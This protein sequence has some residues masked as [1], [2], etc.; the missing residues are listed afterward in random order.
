M[1]TATRKKK[2]APHDPDPRDPLSQSDLQMLASA[3]N[4]IEPPRADK[5]ARKDA[6]PGAIPFDAPRTLVGKADP[7]KAAGIAVRAAD[8]GRVLMLQ[9]STA[10]GRDPNAGTWEFP[11]GRLNDGEHPRDAAKRE[12]QEEMGVRLPRGKHAGSWRSGVYQ[13]F[14]HEVANEDA[15]KL[16]VD[17]EDRRVRNPDDPD[18]DNAEVAAWWHPK[19][20]RYMR[21]LRPELRACKVWSKVEKAQA[22]PALL[23]LRVHGVSSSPGGLR[24]YRMESRDGHYVGRTNPTRIR[25]RKGDVLKV[26]AQDYLQDTQGDVR[27]T[28]AGVVGFDDIPHS[29]RELEAFAG[30]RV[31]GDVAETATRKDAAPGAAGD[32]PPAGD[33]G[34]VSTLGGDG[35]TLAAVHVN[36]PLEGISQAYVNRQTKRRFKPANDSVLQGSFLPVA[37]G[38]EWKQLVYGVVLEPNAIDSQD[39]FMLPHHVERTAHNYLKKAVRGRSSVAKLQ[40][41][42]H[43]GG[44]SRSKASIVPVESFIAPVDFSYDGKEQIKKGSWVLAMHIEDPELWQD[45]LDGKYRAFSVGGSGVRRAVRGAADLV[46]HGL[47]GMIQPNYFEPD[48]RRMAAVAG[49]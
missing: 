30:G 4:A 38:Q 19:H 27:W 40:H 42:A 1:T 31:E 6:A 26:Q 32:L 43:P 7:V 10:Q 28:N 46:P 49:G 14:V 18:G 36:I 37:K 22:H 9:R 47:V 45:F 39:D 15:V 48:P 33:P 12:W 5:L 11:G 24:V 44:F 23:K 25:A 29:W 35:P 3:A 8:T 16:N 41:G 2:L 21:A 34:V 20:L 13:G 17:G